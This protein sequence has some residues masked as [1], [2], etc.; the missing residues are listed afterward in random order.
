MPLK[1]GSLS[2]AL[3][4]V[5]LGFGCSPEKPLSAAA[6][7]RPGTQ[8][9]SPSPRQTPTSSTPAAKPPAPQPK[10]EQLPPISYICPMPQDVDVIENKP[11]VCPKCGMKLV[12]IRLETAWSCINYPEFI[13]DK[14]GSCPMDK[15]ALVQITA[16]E[17]FS[18]PSNPDE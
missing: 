6:Q 16:S 1:T 2:V 18:C 3:A 14:P 7:A 12:P 15:S 13:Q 4:A 8:T 5:L 17:Y 9:A 10:A 11:G